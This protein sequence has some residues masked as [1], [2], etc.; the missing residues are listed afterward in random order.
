MVKCG[1]AFLVCVLDSEDC[2]KY[3]LC[4]LTVFSRYF[5]PFRIFKPQGHIWTLSPP[6]TLW[7]TQLEAS[8]LP[9]APLGSPRTRALRNSLVYVNPYLT[10]STWGW[11]WRQHTCYA[12]GL[13]S[14]LNVCFL[15]CPQVDLLV[16]TL[17]TGSWGVVSL[18]DAAEGFLCVPACFRLGFQNKTLPREQSSIKIDSKNLSG[19]I[20]HPVPAPGSFISLPLCGPELARSVQTKSCVPWG[21]LF[22]LH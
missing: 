21:S 10:V 5:L 18:C 4:L 2:S 8:P 20:I 19:L 11:M 3:S 7:N 1:P 13:C 15:C 17:Q 14:L 22:L 9:P 12:Y 6:L 16:N